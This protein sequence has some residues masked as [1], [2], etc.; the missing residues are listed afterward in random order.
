MINWRAV[1]LAYL[2]FIFI[3]ITCYFPIILIQMF[4]IVIRSAE[5]VNQECLVNDIWHT[6][7]LTFASLISM[8]II[9]HSSLSHGSL[10]LKLLHRLC[11]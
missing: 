4:I 1:E 8:E 7:L 6:V 9:W 11:V 3:E 5:I 10:A 2:H